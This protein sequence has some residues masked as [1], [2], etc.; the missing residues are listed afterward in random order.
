MQSVL[1]IFPS[2]R[3]TIC[4]RR[5]RRGRGGIRENRTI[6]IISTWPTFGVFPARVENGNRTRYRI[7]IGIIWTHV[8][9][10]ASAF[11]LDQSYQLQPA[12]FSMR[13]AY[14]S[15]LEIC[16]NF[17]VPK[18]ERNLHVGRWIADTQLAGITSPS[19]SQ[20]CR[21]GIPTCVWAGRLSLQVR[22]TYHAH[23]NILLLLLS[24]RM[25]RY[26]EGPSP[27]W[28]QFRD[29]SAHRRYNIINR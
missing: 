10:L 17:D 28:A 15:D 16:L 24:E 8:D 13:D 26:P 20:C 18:V 4:V 23:N 14:T 11:G 9:G 2:Q 29:P 5:R 25:S 19:S 12:S 6:R 21:R 22:H 7:A 27:N 3:K 1:C